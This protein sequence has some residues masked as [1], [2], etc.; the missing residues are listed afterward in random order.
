[1]LL[2]PIF[3]KYYIPLYSLS[4]S[5]TE[6]KIFSNFNFTKIIIFYFQTLIYQKTKALTEYPL[7]LTLAI[8]I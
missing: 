7:H 2:S 1:M 6:K 3:L 8:Q 5:S 4:T